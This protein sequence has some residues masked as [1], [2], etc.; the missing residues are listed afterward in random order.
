MELQN[1]DIHELQC[2]YHLRVEVKQSFVLSK[3]RQLLSNV[4]VCIQ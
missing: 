1:I 2:L 4:L 3:K